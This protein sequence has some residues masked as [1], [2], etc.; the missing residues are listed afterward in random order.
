MNDF[1]EADSMLAKYIGQM[2]E[3]ENNSFFRFQKLILGKWLKRNMEL[4]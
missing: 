2:P 3:Q 1:I 4:S